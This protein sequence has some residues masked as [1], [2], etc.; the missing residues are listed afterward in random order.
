VATFLMI[1]PKINF[2]HESGRLKMTGTAFRSSK[3]WPERRSGAFRSHSNTGF[4]TI[5]AFD[6]QT[7]KR[8]LIAIPRQ[9]STAARL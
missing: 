1:F 7:D 5:H 3:K 4:I 2:Y 8:M 9:H 6:G